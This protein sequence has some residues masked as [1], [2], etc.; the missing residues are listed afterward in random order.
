MPK[1]IV[2]CCDGTANE[3]ARHSTNVV[4][5]YSILTQDPAKQVTYYHPGLGTMEPAGA[6]TTLARKVTKLLGQAL[7]Y[8]LANDMRDAYVFLMR[9]YQP[10]DRVFLF[11]FSRGAYTVRAVASLLHM[12]GLIRPD[13]EPLVP[14][15]IRMLMAI[16]RGEDRDRDALH[17]Y[18]RLAEDFKDSMSWT[19]CAPHFVGVWDTVSSVGWVE[20]PLKLPHVANNPSINIGRHAI[21]ID[22]RR[23]FFRTHLWRRP[24][25]PA[26][27][28]GPR[29]E[30]QVWFPGVHCDVG[31]GYAETALSDVALRWMVV[32]AER[33]GLLCDRGRRDALLPPLAPRTMPAAPPPMH[34]SL[35][36]AW[37]LAE[38]VWKKHFNMTTQEWGRRMNLWRRRTLPSAPLVHVSAY[39]RDNAY[40]A[41]I[42][43]NA[44]RVDDDG[45]P[46]GG[47]PGA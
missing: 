38:L 14:Y 3:F 17:A 24:K 6:L 39:E 12:Y 13:N 9:T 7:G 40:R 11:G 5:L 44:V 8:G 41:R 29:D 10:G 46:G 45:A 33:A 37:H 42:P 18:F 30:K 27:P 15:A 4:K 26:T 2:V 1:N 23:A 32:E 31:G 43:N 16:K 25:D 21:A 47:G 19:A 22:E 36:G 20:N 34:E 28:Y 35:K